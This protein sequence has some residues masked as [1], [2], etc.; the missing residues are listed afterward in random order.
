MLRLSVKRILVGVA[1]A[2]A[3]MGVGRATAG[4]DLGDVLK[5]GGVALIVSKFGPQI[6]NA[7]NKLTLQHGVEVKEVTKVVPI[8]SVGQGGFIG[9]AQVMGAE[10]DVDRVKAVAQLEGRFNAFRFKV[11]IPVESEKAIKN[12]KRV[13]GVGVSAIIDIKI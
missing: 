7:I 5:V 8:L 6:N 12:L 2:A 3:L 10:E 1:L 9:A 4:I 11:L 13:N